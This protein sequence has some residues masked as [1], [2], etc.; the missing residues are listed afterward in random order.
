MRPAYVVAAAPYDPRDEG[1]G[2]QKDERPGASITRD[3]RSRKKQRSEMSR[4]RARASQPSVIPRC[5]AAG[6]Y[7]VITRLAR[8]A[9]R[10]RRAHGRGDIEPQHG[11]GGCERPWRA[12]CRREHAGA[13]PCAPYADVQQRIL[14]PR[15]TP[16]CRQ[17]TAVTP[18]V[19][20]FTYEQSAHTV[21]AATYH[22]ITPPPAVDIRYARHAATAH[23][24]AE[25]PTSP[26]YA[27]TL[28]RE[29]VKI[30]SRCFAR[31]R[32]RACCRYATLFTRAPPL[33]PVLRT[34]RR[35]TMLFCC[36]RL[37]LF[38]HCRALIC[39]ADIRMHGCCRRLRVR[40]RRAARAKGP[41]A[42]VE[43]DDAR[44]RKKAGATRTKI[45][46]KRAIAT[47]RLLRASG[48]KRRRR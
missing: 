28:A 22:A 36:C 31:C 13:P 25:C 9:A 4:L 44:R 26:S 48:R 15:H 16:P 1:E 21:A 14:S 38:T 42:A 46:A 39:A 2:Q 12:K 41:Y 18:R 32:S 8:Y 24:A 19:V 40:E 30:R 11:A 17:H 35:T 34:A 33:R 29:V 20:C 37:P 43:G 45:C 27:I 23:Y 6:V 3:A 7:G 10:R 47:A 5:A